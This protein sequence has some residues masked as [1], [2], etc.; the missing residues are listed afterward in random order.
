MFGVIVLNVECKR[1]RNANLVERN[2]V[3]AL[4]YIEYLRLRNRVNGLQLVR[5][6]ASLVMG[7]LAHRYSNPT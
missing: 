4:S 2:P 6:P 1:I 5:L 3:A 7:S